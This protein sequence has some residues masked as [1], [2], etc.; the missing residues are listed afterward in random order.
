MSVS[1]VLVSIILRLDQASRLLGYWLCDSFLVPL[2]YIPQWIHDLM[3]WRK[4]GAQLDVPRRVSAVG[5][6]NCSFSLK[7]VVASFGVCIKHFCCLT[8]FTTGHLAPSVESVPCHLPT[9]VTY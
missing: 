4:R 6:C 1:D 8:P 7:L 2:S 5:F 3:L 9:R